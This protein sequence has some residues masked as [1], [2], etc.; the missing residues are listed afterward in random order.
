M[1]IKL[2]EPDKNEYFNRH[3]TELVSQYLLD[4]VAL[5]GYKEIYKRC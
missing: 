2:N 1:L 5:R 4:I 3:V